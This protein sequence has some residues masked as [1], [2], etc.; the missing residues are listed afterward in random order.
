MNIVYFFFG[1]FVG[2]FPA[3][4]AI[5]LLDILKAEGIISPSKK[6]YP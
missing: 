3:I 5:G 4:T 2:V 6:D 1:I